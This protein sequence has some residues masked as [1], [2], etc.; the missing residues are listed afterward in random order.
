MHY[1]VANSSVATCDSLEKKDQSGLTIQVAVG[2]M[3]LRKS[4]F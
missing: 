3:D 4:V 1:W 2:E